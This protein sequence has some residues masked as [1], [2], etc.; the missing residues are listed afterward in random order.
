MVKRFLT[1]IVL[2]AASQAYGLDW[3]RP[4]CSAFDLERDCFNAYKNE[5]RQLRQQEFR[6]AGLSF[7]YFERPDYSDNEA[8]KAA[9]EA[10]REGA[11]LVSF[12]VEKDGSTSNV[13]VKDKTS[14]EVSVYSG[15]VL[16]AV[17]NWQFVPMDE[18]KPNQEWLFPFLFMSDKCEEG[19]DS[20]S[21]KKDVQPGK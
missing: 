19:K 10:K 1:A 21:C 6:E 16:S 11:L 7:W 8:I 13:V 5:M 12:T 18:A 4:E 2:G 9:F 3:E 15:P 20:E 14:E 17:Q